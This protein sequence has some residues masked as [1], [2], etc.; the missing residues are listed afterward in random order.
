MD[1]M[2]A[3]KALAPAVGAAQPILLKKVVFA[4][5]DDV[6]VPQMGA[7][8]KTSSVV[9]MAA[10]GAAIAAALV[11]KYSGKLVRDREH[12]DILL[13]YG[14]PALTVG[15]I[16]DYFESTPAVSV[17]RSRARAMETAPRV[18]MPAPLPITPTPS[19][20]PVV[21]NQPVVRVNTA[22]HGVF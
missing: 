11:G 10:S 16:M 5:S 22:E 15:L 13:A 17:S 9:N 6:L 1:S 21:V 7:Y 20:A 3:V 12:Q 19:P 2:E 4:T 8:G 14:I 18:Y